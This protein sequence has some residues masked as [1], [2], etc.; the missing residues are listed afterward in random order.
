MKDSK[1]ISFIGTCGVPNQYGGF[2]SFL[3][4]CA[5]LF[6]NAGFNTYVTCD[7]SIYK[8]N[9]RTKFYNVNCI[10]IP[11]KANG[12][13]SIF[14]DLFA[15][16]SVY[17]K[18]KYIV[19]LGVS[20]GPW[21]PLF[22]FLSKVGNKVLAVNSDGVEFRRSKFGYFKRYLLKTFDFLA[23]RF[24]DILIYDNKGLFDFVYDSCKYKAVEISYSGDHV[25]N[26]NNKII[27][28]SALTICRI[29]PENNIELLIDSFLHSNLSCYTIIGNWDGSS[30]GRSLF[31]KYSSHS[32]VILLDPIYNSHEI[33]YHRGSCNFYLHGH[34]VGG[35][36]PSLVEMLYYNCIICCYDVIFN[37]YTAGFSAQ[38]FNN[39]E[40][41]VHV[42]NNSDTTSY[43]HPDR[44]SKRIQYTS[45]SITQKYITVLT[46]YNL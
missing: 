27:P 39:R 34:S 22:S 32:R 37:R 46:D 6:V 9:L 7:K 26:I 24:S 2:E 43:I 12:I 5:P 31:N 33:A 4:N 3:H 18:T 16:L 44:L 41:L 38:Y 36:N 20:G 29:E 8:N 35:T 21:F 11:I 30:Y 17:F 42:L 19:V 14:H 45:K 28:N 40:E 23:Q 15:F 25:I 1:S 10:Y 13:A